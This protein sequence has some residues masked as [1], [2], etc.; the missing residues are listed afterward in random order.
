MSRMRV[1]TGVG[2]VILLASGGALGAMADGMRETPRTPPGPA[3][4][5]GGFSALAV[6]VLSI[7]ADAAAARGDPAEA[8]LQLDM[9]LELEPQRHR[10]VRAPQRLQGEIG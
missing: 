1:L 9:I 8:L 4:L 10:P 7:R 5:L 2:A 3:S 6:Q